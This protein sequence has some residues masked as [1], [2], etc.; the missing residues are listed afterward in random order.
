MPITSFDAILSI[1]I[2]NIIHK[3]YRNYHNGAIIIR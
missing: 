3:K 1:L 2:L